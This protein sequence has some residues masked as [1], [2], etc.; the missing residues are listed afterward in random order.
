MNKKELEKLERK[1][2]ASGLKKSF[3]AAQIG[4][5]DMSLNHAIKGRRKSKPYLD[6]LYKVTEFLK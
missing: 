1:I 4:V 6:I 2:Q 5:S 3:I